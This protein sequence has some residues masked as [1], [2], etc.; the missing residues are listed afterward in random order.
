MPTTHRNTKGP[1][2]VNVYQDV[3]SARW[4][5]WCHVCGH[6]ASSTAEAAARALGARHGPV[7]GDV[8]PE[9]I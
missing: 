7:S 6:V 4:I 5:V 9:G 3:S 2:Q 1:H 8:A